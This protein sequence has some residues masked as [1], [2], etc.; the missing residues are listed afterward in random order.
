MGFESLQ[1]AISSAFK[2]IGRTTK[3]FWGNRFERDKNDLDYEINYEL[4]K[5]KADINHNNSTK[6]AT[7]AMSRKTSLSRPGTSP[8]KVAGD[9]KTQNRT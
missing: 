1:I 8:V 9:Q 2:S 4:I 3:A 5:G 6:R 7:T